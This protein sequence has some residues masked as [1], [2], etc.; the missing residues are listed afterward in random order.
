VNRVL[1]LVS[2][3][4]YGGVESM[5]VTIARSAAL[6]GAMESEFAL[7]F[8]GRAADELRRS[9]A[10]VH[11][12][13][14]ARARNPFSVLRARRALARI[15][16]DRKIDAMV[17]HMTWAQAIFGPVA[18]SAGVPLIFWMHDAASGRPWTEKMARRVRPDLV[19]C[20]SNF[21]AGSLPALYRSVEWR[22]MYCPVAPPPPAD[23][24]QVRRDTSTPDNAIVI[25][26]VGRMEPWKGQM[27]TIEALARI[28]DTPDWRCWM[29]GGAQSRAE[30]RYEAALRDASS[31]HLISDRVIFMGARSDVADLL[32]AAD[33]YC[34]PNLTPEPF[35]IAIVE[36]MYAGLPI[37]T[38]AMGGALEVVADQCGIKLGPSDIDGV[39]AAL[40]SLIA[41]P[42]LRR[43]M[44]RCGTERARAMCDP[45]RQMPMLESIVAS[46]TSGRGRQAGVTAGMSARVKGRAE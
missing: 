41:D 31:R 18:R 16:G 44:G 36:A 19:L 40:R 10:T 43:K 20:N 34:Q 28:K 1:H 35:G 6:A 17:C 45:A 12:I 22:M 29:I 25:A 39:A 46:L 32:A 4:L 13:G 33:I 30:A 3:R 2:G 37:V 38:S 15:I 14:R 23:R 27:A 21:T 7:C 5:L 8:E 42:D 26:Q 11:M 24:A 9:N